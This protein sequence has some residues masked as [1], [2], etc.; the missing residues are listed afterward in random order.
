M[1]YKQLIADYVAGESTAEVAA[2]YG[3]SPTKVGRILREAGVVRSR[4]EA[5]KLALE[6]G[7]A[8]NP[9]KGKGHSE[10]TKEA[11]S[12]AGAKR[13]G[14]LSEPERRVFKETAKQRWDKLS[15]EKKADMQSKAGIALRKTGEEGSEAEKLVF[16]SL[17]S[18]GYG[19]E[20]HVKSYLNGKYEL[21]MLIR[22]HAI[23]IEMDGPSHFLPIW[24][25]ERLNKTIQH[26]IIKTGVLMSM[27]L[28]IVRVKYIVKNLTEKIK[29][30]LCKQVKETVADVVSGKITDKLVE[31]EFKN[32]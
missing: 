28:T 5:Q 14:S 31:I 30:D 17:V 23:A 2:R 6:K 15:P 21:D 24:G 7:K 1:E 8:I 22:E 10:A 20:R 4:S 29:R 11:L 9:T 16:D 18:A 19:V 25:E 32:G 13:W 12:E 3:L 27:G 26:D